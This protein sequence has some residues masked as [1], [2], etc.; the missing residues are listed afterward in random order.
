MLRE[1]TF[2]NQMISLVNALID[3]KELN[4]RRKVLSLELQEFTSKAQQK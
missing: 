4:T 2:L 3:F 1:G